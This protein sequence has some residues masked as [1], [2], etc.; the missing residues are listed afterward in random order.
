MANVPVRT[1]ALLLGGIGVL[2]AAGVIV[3]FNVPV[4]GPAPPRVAIAKPVAKP[5]AAPAPAPVDPNAYVIRGA[6]K[7]DEPIVHGFWKW[8]ESNAPAQG[9]LLI[10]TDLKA[11]TLSVFRGGYEIGTAVILYG[12]EKHPTPTGVYPVLWKKADHESSIY[13][14]KMPYTLRLT[15]DGVAIHGADVAGNGMTHG[16]IGVPVEFAKKLFGVTPLGT[17]VLITNGERLQ[18]GGVVSKLT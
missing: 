4:D 7:I 5:V 17:K 8:D 1:A 12:F 18:V 3:A 6:L 14:A 2:G 15:N 11:Q 16:C 13:D 9:P 10:T